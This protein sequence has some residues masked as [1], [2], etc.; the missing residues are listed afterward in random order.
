M[1][2]VGPRSEFAERRIPGERYGLG[3]TDFG[4]GWIGHTGQTMGWEA[5]V[6]YNRETGSAFTAIVNDTGDL[7]ETAAVVAYELPDLGALIGQ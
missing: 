3:V 2:S 5:L 6:I 4:H 1:S 7:S